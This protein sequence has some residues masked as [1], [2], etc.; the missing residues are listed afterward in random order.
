MV[1]VGAP[2]SRNFN[3]RYL[4]SFSFILIPM[5]IL[6]MAKIL[7]LTQIASVMNKQQQKQWSPASTTEMKQPYRYDP[8]LLEQYFLDNAK[9]LDLYNTNG[10]ATCP[11]VLNDTSPVNTEML[12][13]FDQL[14]AYNTAVDHF[15][16]IPSDLRTQILPD[17]SNVEEVCEATKLH[18]RGLNGIFVNNGISSSSDAGG[19]EPLLPMMRSTK[20][21]GNYTKPVRSTSVIYA[22]LLKPIIR[23]THPFMSLYHLSPTQIYSKNILHQESHEPR[24]FNTRFSF[25]LQTTSTPHPH[26][27]C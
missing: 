19:M 4:A 13:Y 12:H 14:Q 20:M 27:L 23:L 25:H 3:R 21:C 9:S 8:S 15:E 10:V 17:G 7:G 2:A 18:P 24:L 5:T 16:P 1:R 6:G 26:S 22:S 11:I